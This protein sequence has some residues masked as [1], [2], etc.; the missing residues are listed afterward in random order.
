MNRPAAR[1]KHGRRGL[2]TVMVIVVL[3]ILMVMMS[4]M[5][6]R[7]VGDRRQTR[8]ESLYQQTIQLADAGVRLATLRHRAD[9][10][11]SG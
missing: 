7:V 4:Q 3:V 2:A 1:R 5:L 6:R 9:K 8:D 11:Y 10:D